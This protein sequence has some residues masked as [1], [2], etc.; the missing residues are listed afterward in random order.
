MKTS[1]MA[2]SGKLPNLI[3]IGAMKCATTSLYYYL[4]QH[5]QIFMSR[6][7]E[8]NFFVQEDNWAQGVDWYRSQFTGTAK[9][10]GEASPHYT[11]YPF[12]S[13]VAE[14]MAAVV[15]EAQLIYLLRDPVERTLSHYVNNFATN[16]EH[17]TF[18]E[19]MADFHDNL[20]LNRSLYYMQLEQYLHY[21]PRSQILLLTQEEL[22]AER[23]KTLATVFHFLA[24]DS[25]FWTEKFYRLE[26]RSSA[27][28]RKTAVGLGL[29]RLPIRFLQYLPPHV[30]WQCERLLYLPFSRGVE[31]PHPSPELRRRLI[32]HFQDDSRRIQAY[33]GR[34]FAGWCV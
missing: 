32:D 12:Y 21:F 11:N 25:S 1:I 6:K 3:I 34:K 2:K 26:H 17:R 31:K 4:S 29:A 14:R 7:K 16:R 27:K 20:Y 33:A 13:G 15:P 30:R 23:K 10:Y 5:P 24:V 22:Y 28:R 19:A 9:I 18:A 8:L